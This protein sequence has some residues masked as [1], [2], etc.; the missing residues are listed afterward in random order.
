MNQ[1]EKWMVRSRKE[2]LALLAELK[3]EISVNISDFAIEFLISKGYDTAEK[4]DKLVTFS[5]KDIPD[6]SLI[7]DATKFVK[8]LQR[9]IENKEKIVVYGD[10]DADG[11]SATT[12]TLRALQKLG[13]HADFHVNNRFNEGYGINEKGMRR[14]METFPD[15]QLILTVDN[16]I[17]GFEGIKL[18]NE[19]GID[20]IVSDHH[21]AK[22]DGT[23]PDAIAVVDLKRIDVPYPYF[24][25]V[26]GAGLIYKLMKYL[27]K[28]M[29]RDP[30]E[31]HELLAFVAIATVADLVPLREENRLYV[32]EGLKL[33][34]EESLIC[35]NALRNAMGVKEINEETMG[36]RYGP[37]LNAIGRINGDVSPAID[38]FMTDD[39]ITAECLAESLNEINES[40]KKVTIEEFEKARKAILDNPSIVDAPVIVIMGEFHEGV[41]GI[42]AGKVKEEYGK[43]TIILSEIENGLAKGSAR[44]VKGFDLKAALDNCSEY[45]MGYGGHEMAAGL[46]LK[47]ENVQNL[48]LKLSELAFESPPEDE[49]VVY[50]DFPLAVENLSVKMVN[51]INTYL[52]PFGQD[53]EKPIIGLNVAY[54]K[55]TIMK[56]KHLKF[57]ANNVSIIWF[58]GVSKFEEIGSPLRIKCIGLPDVNVY[59]GKINLQFMVQNDRV[60]SGV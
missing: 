6:E 58:N 8:R 50:V 23:V 24:D 53:F 22:N 43:P 21:E 51:D 9:A 41:V 25:E 7:P 17:L 36:F 40:R 46:T 19:K 11:I 13:V 1:N 5:E 28:E 33:I 29:G 26:C 55:L 48:I 32:R 49:S 56:E 2:R 47:R 30:K 4:I 14:L 39:P 16:G 15:V 54:D 37:V 3:G 60:R 57:L 44:S 12:I 35:F 10:Y 59:N 20:V 52:R 34:K 45:L 42:I 31:L 18:A 38:L 27:Y